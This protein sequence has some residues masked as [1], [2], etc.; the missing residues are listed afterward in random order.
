MTK[1]QDTDPGSG[2]GSGSTPKCHGSA[3]LVSR[4]YIQGR[5]GNTPGQGYLESSITDPH[6]SDQEPNPTSHSDADPKPTFFF[7]ADPA[8]HQRDA[9]LQRLAY[10]TFKAPV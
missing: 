1:W 8:P 6:H 7:D 4:Y 5:R 10:R 9:N 3:T 2:S